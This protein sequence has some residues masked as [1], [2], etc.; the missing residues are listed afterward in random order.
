MVYSMKSSD[1]I[2]IHMEACL[3][4]WGCTKEDNLS[5]SNTAV[6]YHFS[7]SPPIRTVHVFTLNP[8]RFSKII[9]FLL[10]QNY[11]SV[12]SKYWNVL[13][14]ITFRVNNE[15]RITRLYILK[16]NFKFL[17]IYK[18][19]PS[20]FYYLVFIKYCIWIAQVTFIKSQK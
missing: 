4:S 13:E 9:A 14:W 5:V 6:S 3:Y 17:C 2:W 19:L 15:T 11:F 10:S 18:S 1:T 8:L 12:Y 16:L 20:T 7:L